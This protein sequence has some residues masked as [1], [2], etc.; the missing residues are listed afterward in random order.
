MR[1]PDV[2]E[3]GRVSDHL[4]YQVDILATLAELAGA[5]IPEDTDGISIIPELMGEKAAGR[6][7]EVHE[8]FYWEYGRQVAVRQGDWKIIR[9]GPDKDWELYDLSKDISEEND[10]SA[11]NQDVVKKLAELAEKA[12][13]P[14][15]PGTYSDPKRELHEKDRKAKWGTSGK[16]PP[17]KKKKPGKVNKIS[18]EN[19]IPADSMKLLRFSSENSGNGKLASHSIDGDPETVWHSQFT[20]KLVGPP[21]ELVIDLGENHSV[22]GFR[23]LARQDNGWNG[24]FAKTEFYLSDS[25]DKFGSSP[26]ATAEFLKRKEAQAADCDGKPVGR[27]VLVKVLSETNGNP[28]AS[29]AEIGVIGTPAEK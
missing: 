10:I 13:T 15:R 26:V 19:L 22:S 6:K 24:A 20:P 12:H 3:A 2:I 5:E 8:Y 23:Y 21:H 16:G 4:F 14:A 1:Y 18:H 25:P 9:Q 7:Q 17:P 28:W 11:K 29:A 27:Y